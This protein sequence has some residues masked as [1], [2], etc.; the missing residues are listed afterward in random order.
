MHLHSSIG[1]DSLQII[2]QIAVT[3][4]SVRNISLYKCECMRAKTWYFRDLHKERDYE[5]EI[6]AS[7]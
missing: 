3:L 1:I 5:C 6:T 4:R 2:T 7:W